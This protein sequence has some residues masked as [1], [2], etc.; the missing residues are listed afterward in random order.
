MS[1]AYG[2]TFIIL[3]DPA[4]PA[5]P[6]GNPRPACADGRDNDGDGQGRLPTDEGCAFANDNTETGGVQPGIDASHLLRAAR[7]AVSR[8]H[9]RRGR[10]NCSGTGKTPY[11]REQLLIDTGLHD[12]ADA[13]QRFDFDMV[14]T[15][16]ASDGFFVQDTKGQTHRRQWRACRASPACS[17]STS[18][19][20]RACASA[21]D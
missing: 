17:P 6:I 21:I 1:N 19:R 3:D 13:T 18:A 20:R 12:K 4:T 2:N 11:P 9:V 8:P 15:R 16:I 14:V 7:V 5:D 10:K